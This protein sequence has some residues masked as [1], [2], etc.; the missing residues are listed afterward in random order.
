MRWVIAIAMLC[1]ATAHADEPPLQSPPAV[2]GLAPQAHDDDAGAGPL[3]HLDP[4]VSTPLGRS[5]LATVERRDAEF[6]LGHAS[7]ALL[8]AEH[9]KDAGSNARGMSAR[10]ELSHDFGF[11]RLIVHGGMNQVDARYGSGTSVNAGVALMTMR[12]LSR[13]TT[14]W[15]SLGT[16]FQKWLGQPGS[17]SGVMLRLGMT[18]R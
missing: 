11:A 12:R 6:D 14:M 8:T 17:S 4:I 15:L 9:W 7:R 16:E 3:L 18:F 2:G 13:W 5:L 10:L 1:S